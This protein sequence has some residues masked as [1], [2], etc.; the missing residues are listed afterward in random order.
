MIRDPAAL[1]LARQLLLP[2]IHP[3]VVTDEIIE[4]AKQQIQLAV[5]LDEQRQRSERLVNGAHNSEEHSG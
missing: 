1:K 4:V 2:N 3:I 5:E